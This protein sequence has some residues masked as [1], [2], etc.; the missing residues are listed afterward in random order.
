M[1]VRLVASPVYIHM[2]VTCL[3]GFL[4]VAYEIGTHYIVQYTIMCTCT[5]VSMRVNPCNPQLVWSGLEQC[6]ERMKESS[7]ERSCQSDIRGKNRVG[8]RPYEIHGMDSV[9]TGWLDPRQIG[10]MIIL[11]PLRVSHM[12]MYINVYTRSK[13]THELRVVILLRMHEHVYTSLLPLIARFCS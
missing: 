9:W 13:D 12:N 10:L 6:K 4:Q 5:C 7:S 11:S 8:T 2:Y 1:S 3:Y